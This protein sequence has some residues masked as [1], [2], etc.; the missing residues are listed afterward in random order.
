MTL[1]LDDWQ[2]WA[3]T[4]IAALAAVYLARAVLPA[5]WLPRF[6]RKRRRGAKA[7]LTVSARS[8]KHE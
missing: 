7:T 8:H 1:P 4:L 5:R 2:F 6:L 3:V